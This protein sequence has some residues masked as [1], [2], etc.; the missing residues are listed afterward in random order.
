MPRASGCYASWNQG[1]ILFGEG[2]DLP[3]AGIRRVA[4]DGGPVEIISRPEA[5]RASAIIT[6]QLLPDGRT[7]IYTV[8][9]NKAGTLHRVVAQRP[10]TGP[11]ADR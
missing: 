5:I 11:R 9:A 6:P 7:V 3:A 1:V 2:G 10:V 8:R 4:E